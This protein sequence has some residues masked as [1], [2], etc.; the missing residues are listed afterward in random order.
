VSPRRTTF[1]SRAFESELD[2]RGPRPADMLLLGKGAASRRSSER[3][4]IRRRRL[5]HVRGLVLRKGKAVAPIPYANQG[6]LIPHTLRVR[7]SRQIV[8]RV[9]RAIGVAGRAGELQLA[10]H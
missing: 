2:K 4:G 7:M 5:I 1:T 9:Q 10:G 3:E 6:N 8:Q